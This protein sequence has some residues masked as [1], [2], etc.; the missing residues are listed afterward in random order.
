MFKKLKPIKNSLKL[1]PLSKIEIA[2]KYSF[3]QERNSEDTTINKRD[4]LFNNHK[5]YLYGYLNDDTTSIDLIYSVLDSKKI[6]GMILGE[7]NKRQISKY[8][9][10]FKRSKDKNKVKDYFNGYD[11]NDLLGKDDYETFFNQVIDSNDEYFVDSEND[12][13]YYFDE[14]RQRKITVPNLSYSLWS[15]KY[16]DKKNHIRLFHGK[17][18]D[19]HLIEEAIVKFDLKFLQESFLKIRKEIHVDQK[20][21]LPTGFY[22]DYLDDMMS[23][24]QEIYSEELF[25]SQCKYTACVFKKI[26]L[27]YNNNIV[28]FPNN[29]VDRLYY[30]ITD[31]YIPN[32]E[33]LFKY[34]NDEYLGRNN[35]KD[36][37]EVIEKIIILGYIFNDLC[38][39]MLDSDINPFKNKLFLKGAFSEYDD[40]V[41]FEIFDE[42][43]Q[44]YMDE[45]YSSRKQE[46]IKLDYAPESMRIRGRVIPHFF[47]LEILK[48]NNVKL[49]SDFKNKENFL[50]IA[51]LFTFSKMLMNLKEREVNGENINYQYTHILDYIEGNVNEHN[52][53]V[54]KS[55]IAEAN[56][57]L[58]LLKLPSFE[59]AEFKN[60]IENSYRNKVIS[61]ISIDSN[62][63]I[64]DALISLYN[65]SKEIERIELKDG[66]E[67]GMEDK[68]IK[69]ENENEALKSIINLPKTLLLDE[70]RR[71]AKEVLISARKNHNENIELLIDKAIS[72]LNLSLNEKKSGIVS[73]LKTNLAEYEPKSELEK[74]FRN[75]IKELSI[76]KGLGENELAEGSDDDHFEGNENDEDD[77]TYV[78]S[79]ND[80]FQ[81]LAIEE[82]SQ[83]NSIINQVKDD[84]IFKNLTQIEIVEKLKDFSVEELISKGF[85]D[86]V[87]TRMTYDKFNGMVLSGK[88]GQISYGSS[89]DDISKLSSSKEE[90]ERLVNITDTLT[91]LPPGLDIGNSNWESVKEV[92]IKKE[93]V[94]SMLNSSKYDENRIKQIEMCLETGK[95]Y[96]DPLYLEFLVT[97]KENLEKREEYLKRYFRNEDNPEEKVYKQLNEELKEGEKLKN[98]KEYYYKRLYESDCPD[99]RKFSLLFKKYI[100]YEPGNKEIEVMNSEETSNPKDLWSRFDEI[101]DDKGRTII[102]NQLKNESEEM[103]KDDFKKRNKKNMLL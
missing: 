8:Y 41:V 21:S 5:N 74:G 76:P 64:Q 88:D 15:C 4:L 84:P 50:E 87:E 101:I 29:L 73:E 55:L 62:K 43:I 48:E 39:D 96:D 67:E 46:L 16:E 18:D 58:Q 83:D 95:S 86:V 45:I 51:N 42:I 19:M 33:S 40:E 60:Y 9:K 12:Y 53:Q 56:T 52:K 44:F 79:G 30:H 65:Q 3:F 66:S 59:Y 20:K 1:D 31:P 7:S 6:S 38:L 57:E 77:E 11:Q 61:E 100:D 34:K 93:M 90:S 69:I 71:K 89:R 54:F 28:L 70:K 27:I 91:S 47:E 49:I 80:M 85:T 23:F 78:Y 68:Y 14:D 97:S 22:E 99:G 82:F 81:E 63:Q 25:D 37:M 10:D 13:V 75:K 17:M 98:D 92:E 24:S 26:N 72:P 103:K 35:K 36:L 94:L 32:I 102:E 2:E